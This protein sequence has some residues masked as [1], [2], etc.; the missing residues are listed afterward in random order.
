MVVARRATQGPPYR[1]FPVE[2]CRAGSACPT[3]FNRGTS[4]NLRR[5]RCPHR[6]AGGVNAPTFCTVSGS[7]AGAET[8][9]N[10]GHV[11]LK[12]YLPTGKEVKKP[13]GFLRIFGYF[14]CAQKVTRRRHGPADF[15]TNSVKT[16]KNRRSKNA[17]AAGI[18][19]NALDYAPPGRVSQ[20]ITCTG[21]S[22]WVVSSML[23]RFQLPAAYG[24]REACDPHTDPTSPITKCEDKK[25]LSR[26]AQG[27]GTASAALTDIV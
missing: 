27:A 14:L 7:G 13:S 15:T 6:P 22:R 8:I 3:A 19:C 24:S 10:L 1:G 20:V 21:F 2:H 4:S 5:G 23:L 9:L 12:P 11:L 17:A 26:T 16:Q 25:G 18:R